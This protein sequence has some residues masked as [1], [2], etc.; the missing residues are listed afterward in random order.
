MHY[1]GIL[2]TDD[3]P[4]TIE[5]SW[6]NDSLFPLGRTTVHVTARDAAGN[7][8]DAE[9][10][11]L[12]VD[13][14]APEL[15]VPGN[16]T[17]EATSATGASVPF[18]AH[19][20]DA[21]STPTIEYS[22]PSG[23]VFALGATTVTVTA[24]DAAGNETVK[25]FQ[26]TVVDTTPPTGSIALDAGATATV[27]GSV[28]ISVA[29][30]DAVGPVRM[31]FS[32][33]TGATWTSWASYAGTAGLT[34]SGADGVRSVI[35]QVA[36]AAGNVGSASDSIVLAI[37]PPTIVVAGIAPGQACDLCTRRF[38]H[39][40]TTAAVGAGSVTVT[41]TLD[42]R[43]F[44]LPG[45]IDP[46]LLTAG[47]HT[48]QVVARDLYGRET[49][50]VVAF[51][52]HVTIEGLICAVQR[53]V[54]EGL[55]APE[56]ETALV[57]KLEAARASRDRGNTRAEVNQLEAF[58]QQL[59]AQ[60]GKKVAPT[61]ADLASGWTEELITRIGRVPAGQTV[62]PGATA[63]ALARP[64]PARAPGRAAETLPATGAA[65]SGTLIAGLA[66]LLAGI[67]LALG[68]RPRRTKARKNRAPTR[69]ARAR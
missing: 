50:Q 3:S 53:A 54:S 68:A 33:D 32:A 11:V 19:A 21:V 27:T 20:T 34:L 39:V 57:A 47:A 36:D 18:T 4:V 8:A 29:F 66:L 60:R 15:T 59:A 44:A 67:G 7:S 62:Q 25:T 45:T 17:E 12:V 51:S 69:R 22:Y 9:F 35:A 28:T 40:D 48:L 30:T 38:V 65:S 16:M 14:T 5:Y 58:A 55:V 42:G 26:V 46:F 52:V 23:T 61:F 1:V 41:A 24:R 10:A 63:A 49:V 64:A 43:A 56:L 2:A 13:T 31:R 6:S 37:P